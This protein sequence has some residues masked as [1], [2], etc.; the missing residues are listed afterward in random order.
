MS[1]PVLDI[2]PATLAREGDQGPIL[3][4]DANGYASISHDATAF[5]AVPFARL[6]A[7]GELL[8]FDGT[9]VVSIDDAGAAITRGQDL[10]FRFLRDGTVWHRSEQLHL[11]IAEDRTVSG[12]DPK[13]GS[14]AIDKDSQYIGPL[15]TRRAIMLATVARVGWM[16]W[17]DPEAVAPGKAK[18]TSI[19]ECDGYRTAAS[20]ALACVTRD[21]TW[22]KRLWIAIARVDGY[23]AELPPWGRDA[24]A[25]ACSLGATRL[26]GY[27]ATRKCAL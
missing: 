7:R 16:S 23:A 5:L 21:K 14:A 24:T 4:L 1:R 8:Q 18:P 17:D 12:T 13:T 6:T 27:F 10:G 26:K 19:A 2:A 15:A 25:S 9:T 22:T 11:A 20:K 3:A